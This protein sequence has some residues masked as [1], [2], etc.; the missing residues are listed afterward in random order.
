MPVA[1]LGFGS[2][3]GN[4]SEFIEKAIEEVRGLKG[5]EIIK[6]SSIYETEPWGVSGQGDYLNS[7]AEIRTELEPQELL[8]ELKRIEKTLGRSDAKRWSEREIDIDLLFY[9][10][11]IID[12]EAMKVPHPQIENRRFVLVPLTE[13]SPLLIHPVFKK[14]VTELLRETT[15]DLKVI[16]YGTQDR[17][18]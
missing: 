17:E 7:A 12:A 18:Q 15:D 4:R 10:D 1:Y 11:R 3:I 13:I 5:T 8:G 16:K 2:N 14:S 9:D 6:L